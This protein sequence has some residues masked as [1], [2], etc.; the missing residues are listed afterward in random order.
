MSENAMIKKAARGSITGFGLYAMLGTLIFTLISG[1]AA[2]LYG[3]SILIAGPLG[4]GYVLFCM[5]IMDDR[6]ADFNTLFAPFTSMNT[7]V[8]TMLAG[9]VY[10]VI[11]CIGMVLLIVPGIIAA[12]GLSM[13]FIIMAENDKVEGI[14]ALQMS[15]DMMK[16]HKWELF[17][18]ICRFIGWLLLCILTFG[19]LALWVEPWMQM[20]YINFYR[21]LKYGQY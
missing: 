2:S 5:K 17:C 6:N 12:L 11:I 15:W 14:E 9:L 4:V 3:L 18:L 7:F 8:Q 10:T 21:K 20:S 16:G 13:T 1:A 19:I